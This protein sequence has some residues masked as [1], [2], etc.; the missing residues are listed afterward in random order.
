MSATLDLPSGRFSLERVRVMGILN[1]TPDSFYDRGRYR[2][3]DRAVGRA[4]EMVAEGA[5]LIDIG[6]EKAGPDGAVPSDEEMRRVVPV[7]EAIRREVAVPISVDTMKPEVARAAMGAGADIINSIGG[8]S[9]DALR[10]V[11]V[12]TRAA[13]IVMHIK[14]QPRVA[15]PN[16]RYTDVVAEV[17]GFLLERVQACLEEGIPPDRILIDPGPGFGKT[18]DHDLALLRGLGSFTSLPYPVV[19]AAS[20]KRFIGEVLGEEAEE[21]LEGSL[22]VAAWGVLQ[23]VKIVRVHDVRPSK[24]VCLMTEAVLNPDLVEASI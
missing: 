3:F 22:A 9:D 23:G 2:R 18:T 16:P 19:L 4:L 12:E 1:P 7:V 20:R 21:R 15:N 13:V 17:R 11:A 10:R 6:G 14:G 5:D 24:R 8:F